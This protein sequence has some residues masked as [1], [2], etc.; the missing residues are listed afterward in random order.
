MNID[1]SDA[2]LLTRGVPLR[3]RGVHSFWHTDHLA[4][5]ASGRTSGM[6]GEPAPIRRREPG[7]RGDTAPES[8][9]RHA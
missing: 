3:I 8:P 1:G 4:I 5:I 7:W 9:R 2:R 6:S